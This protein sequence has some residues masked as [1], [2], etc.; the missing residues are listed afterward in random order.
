MTEKKSK[1]A[2]E[3]ESFYVGSSTL[4]RG[5]SDKPVLFTYRYIALEVIIALLRTLPRGRTSE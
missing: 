3:S 4:S 2:G 1:S 5:A